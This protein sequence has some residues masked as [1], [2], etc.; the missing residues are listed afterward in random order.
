MHLKTI[1]VSYFDREFSSALI[2]TDEQ[3]FIGLVL[4]FTACSARFLFIEFSINKK[5]LIL[6]LV[7]PCF[8]CNTIWF[9]SVD[10]KRCYWCELPSRTGNDCGDFDIK[11]TRTCEEE[12]DGSCIK[13][14]RG[15]TIHFSCER[16]L[17]YPLGSVS[18][19]SP[20]QM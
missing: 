13:F 6:I 11:K 1:E 7:W 2:L 4:F 10:G 17:N 15:D 3:T 18:F 5:L 14:S 8:I 9:Y 20:Q 19:S 12:E 16:I